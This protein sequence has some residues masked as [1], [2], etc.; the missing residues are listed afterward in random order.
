MLCQCYEAIDVCLMH[1]GVFSW[2]ENKGHYFCHQYFTIF[3]SLTVF[4]CCGMLNTSFCNHSEHAFDSVEKYIVF[5]SMSNLKCFKKTFDQFQ[6]IKGFSSLIFSH[7]FDIDRDKIKYSYFK[8]HNL[9]QF[10]CLI[11]FDLFLN[12]A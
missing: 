10:I 2:F 1:F 7:F 6:G 9:F 12:I 11:Y 4:W 5:I 8:F 3:I